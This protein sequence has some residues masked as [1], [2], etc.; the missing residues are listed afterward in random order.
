MESKGVRGNHSKRNSVMLISV[1]VHW[2]H[3]C[4][5][6]KSVYLAIL[7]ITLNFLNDYLS[8]PLT[9]FKSSDHTRPLPLERTTGTWLFFLYQFS[10]MVVDECG[11]W[12]LPSNRLVIMGTRLYTH[13][14]L[15]TTVSLGR[16]WVW[17]WEFPWETV[18][19][20]KSLDSVH[21][22][23]LTLPLPHSHNL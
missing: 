10:P 18:R 9:G 11:Q 19:E 8:L 1:Q 7:T 22:R 20:K 16:V 2:F 3:Y 12:S 13:T 21:T 6:G 14:P 5:D 4:F 15:H 23:F 17:V